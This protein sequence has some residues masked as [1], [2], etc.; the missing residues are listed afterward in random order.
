VKY[1]DKQNLL[2]EAT[3]RLEQL[4]EAAYWRGYKDALLVAER[5]AAW[6]GAGLPKSELARLAKNELEAARKRL[7]G[8][9]DW[10]AA[11]T[12]HEPRL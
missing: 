12:S 4:F 2:H 8:E 11:L 3:L 1:L 9:R 6:A 5:I 7:P 10:G